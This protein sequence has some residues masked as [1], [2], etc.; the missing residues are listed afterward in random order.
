MPLVERR[1]AEALVNIS[2]QG[3]VVETYQ[4]QFGSIMEL[5][6]QQTDFRLF[7][8][9][10]EIN[11]DVKK[12]VVKKLFTSTLKAELVNF[13]MLLLD[14]GRIKFLPGIFNEFNRLADKKKNALNMTII[15]AS[16]LSESQIQ[17]IKQK[18][19]KVYNASS[20]KADIEIDEGLIGGVK[21]KVGDCVIDGSVKGRLN[22]LKE[23]LFK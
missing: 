11:T 15:S 20:V 18:Y 6:N 9:N 19:L 14:K 17:E 21:V 10:P 8:L 23:I 22:S 2:M 5:Y 1:Y 3:R 7:L 12:E 4:Q 13:L 16:P